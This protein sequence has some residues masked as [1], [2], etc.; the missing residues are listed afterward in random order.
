MPKHRTFLLLFSL[1]LAVPARAQEPSPAAAE[2]FEKQVR[3]L[4]VE[5]CLKCH[6]DQKP[7]GGLQLTTRAAVLKG[8]EN[9]PAAVAGKPDDSLLIQ[10]V[11]QSGELK[12]PPKEKL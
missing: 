4:L 3:P 1:A 7:K 6:G 8:G 5:R 9:G 2:F 11:R 12:M 10:A